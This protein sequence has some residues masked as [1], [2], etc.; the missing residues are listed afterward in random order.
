MFTVNVVITPSTDGTPTAGE[1][2]SLDCSINGTSDPAATYQWF[3]GNG[4][5]L[6]NSS[7]LQFSPLRTSDAGIYT[8]Q[9]TLEDSEVMVEGN[10]TV[11]VNCKYTVRYHSA[12]VCTH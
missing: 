6:A 10:A 9:G 1:T 5:L 2:Y 3:D 4:A 12:T 8:C 7:Q 11:N